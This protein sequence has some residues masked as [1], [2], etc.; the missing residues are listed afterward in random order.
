MLD[1]PTLSSNG[2]TLKPLTLSYANDLAEACQDGELWKINETSVPE[3]DKVID[4]INT[5]ESMP[6]RKAFVVIDESTGKAIGSTSFHDILPFAKR[7]EIGYTWYAQSYWRTHVN[8]TCKLM[9]LTYIFETLEYQTVGWRADIG[10]RRSQ[11]AIERL[12]AKKD[13]VIR[14]NRVCRDGVISD[15]AM[16][17][18]VKSEWPQVKAELMKKLK[19]Y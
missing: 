8:T 7:L 14:G 15:T 18:L 11:E 4:Y 2:I 6:D 17:S 16:Y 19:T 9:L 10:N 13:G 1:L 3:P 5:A 12:G